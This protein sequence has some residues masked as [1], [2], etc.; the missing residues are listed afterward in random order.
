MNS[1]TLCK[2]PEDCR[3]LVLKYLSDCDKFYASKVFRILCNLLFRGF[4]LSEKFES[5][6]NHPMNS[7]ERGALPEKTKDSSFGSGIVNA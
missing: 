5:L 3:I 1:V 4:N 2:K 7:R 6:L